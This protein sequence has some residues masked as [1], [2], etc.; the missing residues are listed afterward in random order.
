MPIKL[1]LQINIKD[2]KLPSNNDF[3]TWINIALKKHIKNA[4]V[5]IRIIDEKESAHLNE[6]YRHKAG[7]TNVLSFPYEKD[8]E[9]KIPLIGDIAICA[10]LA[11][12][13]AKEQNKPTLSHWTHLTVHGCLHLI[14]YKHQTN[15][16]ANIMEKEETD[17]L[18][19]INHFRHPAPAT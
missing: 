14:G 17:I 2:Q 11:T 3:K 4:E 8:P 16:Q 5:C 6:T 1:T 13:E 19:K 7:P 9:D 12:K 18:E 10:P 15:Q